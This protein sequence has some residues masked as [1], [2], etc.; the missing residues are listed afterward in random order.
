MRRR[1]R[2]RR[3][4]GREGG[5]RRRNNIP[6]LIAGVLMNR[7]ANGDDFT[8]R[9]KM[10]LQLLFFDIKRNVADEDSIGLG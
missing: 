9:S 8:T 5:R 4:G 3:E 10:V 6:L 2:S 7:E 1:S